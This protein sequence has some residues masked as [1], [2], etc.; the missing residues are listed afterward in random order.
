MATPGRLSGRP[1]DSPFQKT[2]LPCCTGGRALMRGHTTM[3]SEAQILLK[4]V[5]AGLLGAVIGIE[6]EWKHKPI[7]LRTN[8][9]IAIIGALVMLLSEQ[10]TRGVG[11]DPPSRIAAA[12]IQGL[13]FLGA[14]AIL[15]GRGPVTGLTTAAVLL[16]V[17][18]IGLATGAG[19]WLLAV[20]GTVIT[21]LV[22]AGFGEF[23]EW[24]HSK[25]KTA[26]YSFEA[27]DPLKAFIEIN[28]VLGEKNIRL[29]NITAES[30]G[31]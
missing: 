15:H 25:C 4:L 18:V 13:G 24:V 1:Q 19:A 28:R 6:R 26:T 7:G 22:L 9:L 21:L 11:V 14:G 29:H 17:A 12:L 23:E 30:E 10:I 20:S 16:A 2:A 8:M 31:P 5:V 27:A 3:G